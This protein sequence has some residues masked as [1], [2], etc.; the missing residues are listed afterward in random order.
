[1]NSWPVKALQKGFVFST[2]VTP[3]FLIYFGSSRSPFPIPLCL[4][5]TH[6]VAANDMFCDIT[7]ETDF[8]KKHPRL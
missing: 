6:S 8:P 4:C 2:L 7:D 3:S 5:L 1:M